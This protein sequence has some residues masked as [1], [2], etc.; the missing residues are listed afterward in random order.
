MKSLGEYLQNERQALG[1]TLEQIS[2]DTRISMNM[3]RAIE[4]GNVERL[5]APVLVKGFLR[6]YAKK[7]SLDPEAVIVKYQDLIE[8]RYARQE[9]LDRFHLR[10]RPERSRRRGV[11][12]LSTLVL[13]ATL[14]FVV[15]W[16]R[17]SP[18]QPS[19]PLPDPE[20]SGPEAIQATTQ[21]ASDSELRQEPS[22][23]LVQQPSEPLPTVASPESGSAAVTPQASQPY[24]S[25]AEGS[26]VPEKRVS[27]PPEA[28]E[29]V[30]DVSSTSPLYVLRAEILETTWIN[31]AIDDGQEIEYLLRPNETLTWR[32]VSGYRLL[33]GNAAGLRLYLNDQ[34]LKSL[35][36]SGQV[37]RLQLPDA[38]LIVT[39]S[40]ETPNQ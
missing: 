6:A 16:F 19:S 11:V 12:L 29:Q 10:M 18:I 37:V 9:A 24:A 30:V 36:N 8:E 13:L 26:P 7:I 39:S 14:V 35:G 17:R 15:L 28:A 22:T 27:S 32:A 33:I 20:I 2:L 38:S 31:M 1:V 23:T 21:P 25:S 40:S 3:L 4:E 5:P 34:P